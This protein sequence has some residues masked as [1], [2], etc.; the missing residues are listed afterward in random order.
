MTGAQVEYSTLE[1]NPDQTE[2]GVVGPEVWRE[3]PG[4]HLEAQYP[5]PV[6]FPPDKKSFMDNY[7]HPQ[8]E[9]Q[10]H[11]ICGI[12]RR[13]FY[14]ILGFAVLIVVGA[15]AG[16]VDGG[17]H[18]ASAHR[19]SNTSTLSN[20]SS[21]HILGT[22][23][24]AATTFNT[25][26][27]GGW[28]AKHVIFQDPNSHLI[29]RRY[30]SRNGTWVT[31]D[32]TAYLATGTTPL[33]LSPGAPLAAASCSDWACGQS[34]MFFLDSH[35]KIGTVRDKLLSQDQNIWNYYSINSS[36]VWNGSQLAAAYNWR[37][38][39]ENTG[40]FV[41]AYQ[42][43]TGT[44]DVAYGLTE[45]GSPTEI[46]S[47]KIV[48]ANTSLAIVSQMDESRSFKSGLDVMAELNSRSTQLESYTYDNDSWIDGNTLKQYLFS[49]S[50]RTA[51]LHLH[52]RR[53]CF[54]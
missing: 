36:A 44:V 33:K 39:S 51:S 28:Y 34:N 19:H 41:V 50:R 12:S 26:V 45:W 42:D 2:D 22:S 17:L 14:I 24:L 3:A 15:V 11:R 13:K 1:V 27:D 4:A 25:S 35:N 6:I 30:D 20:T 49:L 31:L 40:R 54:W 53:H 43:N 29:A 37:N 16:G 23:K 7:S 21:V 8:Q 9:I 38:S 10:Q 48:A 46:I 52:C 47:T 18:A 5:Q 32:I